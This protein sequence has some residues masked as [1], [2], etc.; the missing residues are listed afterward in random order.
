MGVGD[1]VHGSEN[2]DAGK[3]KPSSIALGKVVKNWD[4]LHP[5]MVQVSINVEEGK[6]VTSDWMPV[7][8]PYAANNCGLYLLPEVGSMVVIGYIDDNS[9]S[10]VVIGSL[11]LKNTV[12]NVSIPSG[13]TDKDNGVKLF[14][15]SKGQLIKIDESSG[16]QEIEI[17]TSKKQRVL[18]DDK[19]EC[20]EVSSGGSDNM[21]KIDGKGGKISIEAKSGISLKVGG[22]DSIE[23]N[24]TETAIK[25]QRLSHDG[26][27]MELKG[28]QSKIEGSVVEIKSNGNMTIQSSAIAQIKGSMLKLN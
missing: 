26:D 23:I 25:S 12:A 19:N 27:V 14:A 7:L 24:S 9:V 21:I 10:P 13:A 1:S 6:E 5:G 15:T 28:K 17:I 2:D 3:N 18:L 16:K 22:K 20:V 4:A 11:W 8:S